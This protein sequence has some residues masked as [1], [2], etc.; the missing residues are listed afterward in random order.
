[1]KCYTGLLIAFLCAAGSAAAQAPPVVQP[2]LEPIV[3]ALEP[4]ALRTALSRPLPEAQR[5]VI[6]PA[7]E[8]AVLGLSHL[9]K[10][11]FA[12]AQLDW[13]QFMAKAT[14]AATRLLISIKPVVAKDAAGQIA[15]IKLKSDRPFAASMILSPRLIPLFQG[16][17]GDRLVA[18]VPD[19]HTVYLFSRNFGEFKA[20]GQKILNDHVDAIYP[21]SIE[22]FEI[23]RDGILCIGGFDDGADPVPSAA[24][25]PGKT[26]P[27][28]AKPKPELPRPPAPSS[29][30]PRRKTEPAKPK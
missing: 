3:A 19:R 24:A 28:D 21:C 5:T 10:E 22:A 13:G 29:D 12:A 4:I 27:G 15:Y 26:K 20:F 25:S 17:L 2:A 9:T 16:L 6:A 8:D 18:L 30:V 14:A 11:E 1:M 23:T 7:R